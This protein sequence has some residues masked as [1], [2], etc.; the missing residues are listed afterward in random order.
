M[1]HVR[2]SFRVHEAMLDRDVVAESAE[3]NR[4]AA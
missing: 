1:Q 3:K 2:Q 4:R